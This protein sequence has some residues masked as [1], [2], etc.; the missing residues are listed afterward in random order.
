MIFVDEI[1][2]NKLNLNG[3]DLVVQDLEYVETKN[4]FSRKK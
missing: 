1:N 4:Q 3:N 2:E